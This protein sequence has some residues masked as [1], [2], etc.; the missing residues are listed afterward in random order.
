MPLP[1]PRALRQ[2]VFARVCVCAARG[3][4]DCQNSLCPAAESAVRTAG[5]ESAEAQRQRTGAEGPEEGDGGDEGE[6]EGFWSSLV[7]PTSFL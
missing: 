1:F 4:P 7:T 6:S 2:A 3:L 5:G